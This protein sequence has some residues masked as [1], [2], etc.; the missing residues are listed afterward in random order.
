M[1]EIHREVLP[2]KITN[3]HMGKE[4]KSQ[5]PGSFITVADHILRVLSPSTSASPRSSWDFVQ[6]D[7]ARSSWDFVQLD[8]A[9]SSWGFVQIDLAQSSW[10][11]V[12][13]DLA[14]SS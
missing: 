2:H 11:F 6:L 14:Q 10:G 1:M 4:P 8:L 13:I 7:L 5:K 3:Q 12:Q 9:R